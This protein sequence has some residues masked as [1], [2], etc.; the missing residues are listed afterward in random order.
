MG[1]VS[2]AEAAGLLGVHPQ[3]VHQRIRDGSLPAKRIGSQ[4]S[5]EEADLEVVRF[6]KA[7]GRPLS[8]RSAWVMEVVAAGD[9]RALAQLS[10][11]ERSRARCRL[12]DLTALE[13]A[14]D[15]GESSAALS[16][17]IG[18]WWARLRTS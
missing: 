12:W 13:S 8:A 1:R 5:I 11:S 15:L 17:A 4:W 6:R 10:P 14:D 2:V 9:E 7:S 3:R 16:V 18:H